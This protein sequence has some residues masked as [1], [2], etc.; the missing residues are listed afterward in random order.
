MGNITK[1]LSRREFACKCGCGFDT[2]DYETVAVIQD[3]CD[4]FNCR[5]TINSGCRCEAH[6]KAIKGSKNSYHK[7]A[8]AADCDFH[9]VSSLEVHEYL[10]NKYPSKYGFG[11]YNNF[12]HIDTRSGIPARWDERNK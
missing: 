4:H 2:V 7:K 12:N 11:I 9:G 8:R 3:V 10:C 1:N 5:V 6:N